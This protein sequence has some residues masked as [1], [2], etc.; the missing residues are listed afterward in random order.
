MHFS[1]DFDLKSWKHP[2]EG[3]TWN[4]R[5]APVL[6]DEDIREHF[7]AMCSKKLGNHTKD[8]SQRPWST[9]VRA[10]VTTSER[11]PCDPYVGWLND[12]VGMGQNLVPLV[13]PKI[14]GIYGCSSH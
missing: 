11:P 3:L 4:T 13:N 12:N 1:G 10:Q 7:D 6:E 8:L 9:A 5:K 2:P 14:A